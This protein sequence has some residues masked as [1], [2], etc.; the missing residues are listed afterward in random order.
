MLTGSGISFTWYKLSSIITQSCCLSFSDVYISKRH[1][2]KYYRQTPGFSRENFPKL[3]VTF[4]HFILLEKNLLRQCPAEVLF[5]VKNTFLE[6]S[7]S[8]WKFILQ[9]LSFIYWLIYLLLLIYS[10]A[11]NFW[12]TIHVSWKTEPHLPK[13]IFTQVAS[14]NA[15]DKSYLFELWTTSFVVILSCHKFI[16]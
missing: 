6:N 8:F 16:S 11:I 3:P 15:L 2:K 14:E 9:S 13:N 10:K 7:S 5:F 12:R 1:Y 4:S